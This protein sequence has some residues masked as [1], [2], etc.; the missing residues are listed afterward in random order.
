MG[1]TAEKL[2]YLKETKNQIKQAL[3][4]PSNI[5]RDYPDLIK[6][7]IDNQPTS[8]VSNGVC[9]NALDVPLVSLGIDGQSEQ[10]QYDGYNL[11]NYKDVEP[12]K[13]INSDTGVISDSSWLA[14]CGYIPVKP[15]KTYSRS[16]NGTGGNCCLDSNKNFISTM[17]GT[18]FTTPDNCYYV[19]FNMVY[20]DYYNTGLYKGFVM[21]EGDTLKPYEPY[22]GGQPS[23]NPNYPQDIEVVDGYNI[24][25]YK[26]FKSGNENNWKIEEVENGIKVTRFSEY[27]SGQPKINLDL[28]ADTEYTCDF[29]VEEYSKG[30]PSLVIYKDDVA[31]KYIT[32]PPYTFR[33]N[34]NGK[35]SIGIVVDSSSYVII[36]NI[37]LIEGKKQKPYLPYGHIGLEQ[38][39]KNKY[40]IPNSN[41]NTF[42][43]IDITYIENTSEININGTATSDLGS[44]LNI[45]SILLKKG[46]YSI[47]VNG[48]NVHSI[49]LDRIYLRNEDK[50]TV[51]INNITSNITKS[52]T[53]N[54]DTNIRVYFVIKGGSTYSNQKIKIQ[55]EEGSTAT[56]YEPYH[57]PKLIPINLNGNS[58]AKVGDIK[59]K[60]IIH[61]NGEVEIEK[62]IGKVNLKNVTSWF[63]DKELSNS[64]RFYTNEIIYANGGLT[65]SNYFKTSNIQNINTVDEQGICAVNNRQIALRINKTLVTNVDELKQ[66]LLEHD[67]EVYYKLI[68]A[69][70][71]KLPSIATIQLWQGTNIFEL[72]TNLDTIFEMEYVV[73]KDYLETQNLLNAVEGE[74]I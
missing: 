73:N 5:F 55:I 24:V 44:A 41:S 36:K 10:K 3:E 47:S 11:Y 64:N 58:L 74:N 69:E 18:T 68:N 63:Q 65:L 22:L 7:Y 59:D 53:L 14:F 60:L 46:L 2:V 25:D 37:Q 40:Y 27:S 62:R 67:V 17:N 34:S 54:E 50:L 12:L 33:T 32:Y 15:N 56:P 35:Y 20:S 49:D 38:S 43:G 1:T 28:K 31:I 29:I 57:E 23:P 21:N 51:I 72:I 66:W 9:T 26:K 48:L 39:G 71:I 42:R 16:A 52:F 13:Y 4:T 70:I 19:G 6:K 45:D 8:K 30:L 61:R